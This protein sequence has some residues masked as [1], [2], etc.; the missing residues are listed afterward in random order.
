MATCTDQPH[1]INKT[2]PP[3]TTHGTPAAHAR[4]LNISPRIY[5]D[6]LCYGIS[7]INDANMTFAT[8]SSPLEFYYIRNGKP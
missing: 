7:G 2:N 5:F 6:G 1:N 4:Y 3:M 8:A